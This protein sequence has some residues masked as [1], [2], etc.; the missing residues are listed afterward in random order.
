MMMMMMIDDDARRMDIFD[1]V[2]FF[3]FLDYNVERWALHRRS[4][5]ST[6][7]KR[8]HYSEAATHTPVP[9]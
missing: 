7:Q 3:R 1:E 9:Q 4:I 6:K 5:Q 8:W 2:V